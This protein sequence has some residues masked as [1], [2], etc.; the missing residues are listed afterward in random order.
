M[1]RKTSKIATHQTVAERP[2]A[3]TPRAIVDGARV[4]RALLAPLVVFLAVFLAA[5]R[6]EAQTPT[7]NSGNEIK[8]VDDGGADDYPGQKD[9]NYL[10]LNYATTNDAVRARW[11]FDDTSWSGN[12]TGDGCVLFDQDQDG[13]ANI[14]FCV[15]VEK[16]GAFKA[17][18]AYNCVSD[19]RSDRC[20]QP[21][22]VTT[23][24][25]SSGNALV[26]T[27]DP[28]AII[29]SHT[30]GN[31]CGA[32][33]GCYTQDTEAEAI[34]MFSDFGGIPTT[35]VNVC[36]YP[37][38]EPN[39]DPSDCVFTP[40]NGFLSIVK[41]AGG[42]TNTGFVFNLGTGQ[43]FQ[44]G[45]SSKTVKEGDDNLFSVRPN[46]DD[47]NQPI[48]GVPTY[49]LSEAI[50]V[51]WVLT[52]AG[53]VIEGNGSVGTPDT[54][55]ITGSATASG[56]VQD[57]VIKSG[58]KTTCTFTNAEGKKTPAI[59]T[60]QS[61]TV[62]LFDSA[63][64]SGLKINGGAASVEFQL[65]DTLANCRSFTTTTGQVGSTQGPYSVDATMTSVTLDTVAGGGISATNGND[66]FW[67]VHYSGNTF[68]N[69]KFDCS[70]KT[71]V[72]I[73]FDNSLT[74]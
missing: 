16:A 21:T 27:T 61:A 30:Q 44:D 51:G 68:N 29:A 7:F 71:N 23:T 12:N 2:P 9:L 22:L 6:S 17:F 42:D 65:Y 39:S 3:G 52:G 4:S 72:V 55:P 20:T 62:K 64:I 43:T 31:T 50:P 32:K 69:E 34:V 74:P 25:T 36:T 28:F 5:G 57:I 60:T 19:A 38:Q 8:A 24:L 54:F 58:L 13:K 47:S 49:D 67:R 1:F 18:R 53:C 70:E 33:Q 37:S 41:D 46:T 10:S 35:F 40:N 14:A 48:A 73:E 66:Y 59:S 63:T 45:T 15:T 11:G 26:K 56:G